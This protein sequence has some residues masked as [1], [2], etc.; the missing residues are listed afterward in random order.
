MAQFVIALLN[1]LME[2]IQLL[3]KVSSYGLLE[4]HK[5]ANWS[6]RQGNEEVKKKH[7]HLHFSF[8]P[9]RKFVFKPKYWANLF[10]YIYIFFI[11]SFTSSS[12]WRKDQFAFL[13][14]STS[15]YCTD[16]GIL[17]DTVPLNSLSPWP[18]W[19]FMSQSPN[20]IMVPESDNQERIMEQRGKHSV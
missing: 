2:P 15:Y 8:S 7:K 11:L 17:R 19:Y 3:D 4:N 1:I 6:L 16:A 10:K 5:T 13:W 12:P 20:Q 18:C 14:F 9:W